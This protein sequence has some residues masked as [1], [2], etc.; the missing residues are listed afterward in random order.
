MNKAH[1]MPSLPFFFNIKIYT[2]IHF[3]PNTETKTKRLS[4]NNGLATY[5]MIMISNEKQFKNSLPCIP[6]TIMY[7]IC[8]GP[9]VIAVTKFSVWV[10]RT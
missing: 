9:I 2:Y 7:Y 6:V 4:H 3:F 5:F 1:S 8:I 10:T